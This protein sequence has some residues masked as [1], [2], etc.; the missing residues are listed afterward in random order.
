MGVVYCALDSLLNRRV[1][2]KV[3]SDAI[4][5]DRD[6]RERFLREAQAAGS[7]QH[8]NVVTIY[9]FGEI[10]GHLYIAMEYVEGED[11]EDLLRSGL[12]LPLDAKLDL[13]INVLQGLAFAHKRGVVHRDI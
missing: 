11:L 6:L 2:I 3:M 7:L 1:A 10:D 4:A 8:P 5:Q 9:D 13:V 12:P